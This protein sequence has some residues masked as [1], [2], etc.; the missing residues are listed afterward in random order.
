MSCSE[1]R[2]NPFFEESKL[3]YGAVEFDKIQSSDYLPAFEEGF[4][5]FKADIDAV[6]ACPDTPT[7]E[8]TIEALESS[9]RLL[10]KVSA[11]FFN[12]METDADDLMKETEEK[13]IPM[14]TEADSYLYMNEVIFKRI[15]QL[16]DSKD[17]GDLTTE[18]IKVLEKYYR[19]FVKGGA[20]LDDKAKAR[21][22]EIQNRLGEL[23]IKFAKNN[24][25][26]SNAY[27]L[28]VTDIKRLEGL[29]QDQLEAAATRAKEKGLQGWA[30]N[31]QKPCWIPF[32]QTCKDRNLREQMYKAYYSRGNNNNEF[33]NKAIVKEI[34]TLRLELANLLGY[35]TFADY[36]LED[37]MAKTPQSVTDDAKILGAPSGFPIT[38]REVNLSAGARFVIPLTGKILTMPGLPKV[39]AAVK[40]E[41]MP[42]RE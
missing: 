37:R 42:W 32:L 1:N 13:V 15:R 30:F 25:D 9:G 17:N 34:L 26:E 2:N 6:A 10:N 8:N 11:V 40:M 18:Q 29:S 7:F 31:V 19:R 24:L 16:Y 27:V 3:P 23:R 21:F 38:I 33:D 22:V 5:Q 14:Q 35:E 39:P 36:Q 12:L 4:R 20:L 41:D 28:N